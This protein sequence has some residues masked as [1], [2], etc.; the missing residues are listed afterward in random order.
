MAHLKKMVILVCLLYKVLAEVSNFIGSAPHRGVSQLVQSLKDTVFWDVT[1]CNPV[2]K[3]SKFRWLISHSFPHLN[4]ESRVSPNVG[5]FLPH[6]TTSYQKRHLYK[7]PAALTPNSL[8]GVVNFF[9]FY[10]K[11]SY[12]YNFNR[13]KCFVDWKFRFRFSVGGGG[14]GG[15]Y[16]S[17]CHYV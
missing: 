12:L 8:F 1:Q 7:F 3:L 5:S 13:W 16:F 4:S 10:Q 14:G 2:K 9:L 11:I 6:K 15:K 17:F